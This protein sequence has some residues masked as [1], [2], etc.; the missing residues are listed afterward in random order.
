MIKIKILYTTVILFMLTFWGCMSYNTVNDFASTSL[1]SVKKYEEI[2]YSFKKNCIDDC[3]NKKLIDLNISL[4][5]CDCMADARAD[6][7]TM[8]IYKAIRGYFEGLTNLSN[9]ELTNYRLDS[10]SK[11][12]S[13]NDLDS[14]KFDQ[15]ETEAYS[16]ISSILL[17]AFTDGYR[18]SK[19]KAYIRQAN[20]S[21]K[22]L[23]S[24]LSF[25]LSA[26]LNGK[27]DIQI[28]K[29]EKTCFNLTK[30]KTLSTYEKRLS[31]KDYFI[32][33]ERMQ[34]IKESINT[35]AKGLKKLAEGHQKLYD[36]LN[37]LNADEIKV[38]I[39]QYGS[40]IK[41]IISEFNK[42]GK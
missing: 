7:V 30:D 31:I 17:K 36:N 39:T 5:D 34:K 4:A 32:D 40:E 33:I 15:K 37:T 3:Q 2:N 10:I 12:V 20:E 24:Y 18:I 6:S 8:I 22:I 42:L 41:D 11:S 23:T 29:A 16:N 19:I 25:N 21:V 13:G 26:N 38:Q 35:F 14:M 27:I 1:N 9:D 28:Q